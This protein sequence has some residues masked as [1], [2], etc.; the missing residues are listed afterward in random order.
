MP[1]SKACTGRTVAQSLPVNSKMRCARGFKVFPQYVMVFYNHGS[2]AA[3]T[4]I[5]RLSWG[6]PGVRGW[7]QLRSLKRDG[8]GSLNPGECFCRTTVAMRLVGAYSTDMHT[9]SLRWTFFLADFWSRST[10]WDD[11]DG[12]YS[13]NAIGDN[14]NG[15]PYPALLVSVVHPLIA[16]GPPTCTSSFAGRDGRWHVFGLSPPSNHAW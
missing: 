16:E 14:T 5:W 2:G 7:L 8:P 3:P 6:W 1:S 4:R 12:V 11:N 15:G 9:L 10:T 13:F